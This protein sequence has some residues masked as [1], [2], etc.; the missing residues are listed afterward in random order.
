MRLL[1]RD[2]ARNAILIERCEPGTPLSAAGPDA[3]LDVL[4]GLLPRLWKPAGAP[5]HTLADEAAWWAGYLP[6]EWEAHG[7]PF[8]RRLLDA[9]VDALEDA[10]ADAGRAGAAA[11]GS[12][13]RQR[14]CRA[15]A[16]RGS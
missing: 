7:R 14:A 15:S 13:R 4:I 12:A 3:A 16:S 8:E 10:G 1:D 11:P 9:A 2:D 6:R 5:F